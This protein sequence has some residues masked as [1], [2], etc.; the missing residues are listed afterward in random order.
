M[1]Q[2]ANIWLL[3]ALIA[4]SAAAATPSSPPQQH[5]TPKPNADGPTL[6]GERFAAW[7]LDHGR[8]YPT[9]A[10]RHH[11][12]RTWAA[13]EAWAAAAN[14]RNRGTSVTHTLSALGPFA[15]LTETQFRE[16]L[17]F[18]PRATAPEED[19]ETEEGEEENDGDGTGEKTRLEQAVAGASASAAARNVS[20][21]AS[22]APSVDWVGAGAVGR[23]GQILLA[24]S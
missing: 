7:A 8:V 17:G 2:A 20:L 12:S 15:D 3:G 1:A 9:P 24:T 10:A 11:A 16:R 22:A 23:A 5:S 6:A 18:K 21:T 4:T 19:T 13:N 14:A